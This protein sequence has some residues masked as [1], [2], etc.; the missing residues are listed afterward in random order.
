ML[1]VTQKKKKDGAYAIFI[2]PPVETGGY[3]MN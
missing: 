3:K 1:D 2:I